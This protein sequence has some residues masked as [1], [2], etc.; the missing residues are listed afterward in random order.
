MTSRTGNLKLAISN[1]QLAISVYY[2]GVTLIADAGQ[3]RILLKT[4]TGT[5]GYK[6]A[7]FQT[8][9]HQPSIG[10]NAGEHY[11]FIWS[12]EQSS[13]SGTTPNINFS[14][15]TLLAVNWSPNNVERPFANSIIFDNTIINQDIYVTHMDIG[16]SQSNNYYMT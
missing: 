5:T 11:T 13:V 12:V 3:Q 8:I 7:K 6:I 16:G 15:N 14:D 10:G 4:I 9:S 1:Y 2:F